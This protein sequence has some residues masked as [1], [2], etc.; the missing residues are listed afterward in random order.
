MSRQLCRYDDLQ[1]IQFWANSMHV[2]KNLLI[3]PETS[4]SSVPAMQ[5]SKWTE[6]FTG[7]TFRS[8]ISGN[9]LNEKSNCPPGFSPPD[10]LAFQR[11]SQSN[12]LFLKTGLH[13]PVDAV[14]SHNRRKEYFQQGRKEP[15]KKSINSLKVPPTLSVTH[16]PVIKITPT[17][18]TKDTSQK[19]KV[20]LHPVPTSC[21]SISPPLNQRILPYASRFTKRGW[22]MALVTSQDDFS[23]TESWTAPTITA[24]DNHSKANSRKLKKPKR[25]IIS[26]SGFRDY[27]SINSV[28][29]KLDAPNPFKTTESTESIVQPI[30]VRCHLCEKTDVTVCSACEKVRYCSKRCQLK[31]LPRHKTF[32]PAARKHFEKRHIR[33]EQTC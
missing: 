4:E 24:I 26:V 17:L 6:T 9:T 31:D 21:R 28:S 7:Q 14:D 1:S 3:T 2:V 18:L 11:G 23:N 10:L 20:S 22:D 25:A 12:K 27:I 16:L 5:N 13:T 8:P 30:K 33:M 15:L 32:C 29:A 19:D